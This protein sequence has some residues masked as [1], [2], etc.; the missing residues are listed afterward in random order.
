MIMSGL[1]LSSFVGLLKFVPQSLISS[2]S[3]PLDQISSPF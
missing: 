2:I 1:E 3:L